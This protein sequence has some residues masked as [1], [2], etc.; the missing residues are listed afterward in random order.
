MLL[1]GMAEAGGGRL[2]DAEHAAEISE[3]VLGE[4]MEG[5]AALLERTTLR[6]AVPANVRA[7]LIGGW[8]HTVLPGAVELLIGTLLPEVAVRA[9]LRLHCPAGE[10]GTAILLGASARGALPDGGATLEAHPVEAGL[11]LAHGRENNACPRDIEVSLAALT[12]WQAD[13]LRKALTMNRKGD[14]A[15]AKHYLEREIRWMERYARGLPNADPLLA[16]LVLLQRR[17]EAGF[18]PRLRKELYMASAG[19]AFAKFD[20][21]SAR[22]M[23]LS[24]RLR[25]ER[26]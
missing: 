7:E 3:V 24:E 22:R 8:S 16:E 4:L 20:H 1:G 14:R 19:R 2:H 5:R 17:A 12:A 15:G 23:S 13:V 9:V 11:T 25:G 26:C 18:D 21:R 10:P 6:F